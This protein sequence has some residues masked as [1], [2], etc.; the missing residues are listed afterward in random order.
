MKERASLQYSVYIEE[1][2]D[3]LRRLLEKSVSS[4][5]IVHK[6]LQELSRQ[7]K[8]NTDALLTMEVAT[9][10]TNMRHETM[11]VDFFLHDISQTI[12][13]YVRHQ[14]QQTMPP[15]TPEATLGAPDASPSPGANMPIPTMDNLKGMLEQ[16]QRAPNFEDSSSDT[17][18][19]YL[20]DLTSKLQEFKDSNDIP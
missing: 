14:L 18:K 2:G 6:Q 12:A 5:A 8:G 1:V 10:L 4:A 19:D 11:N 15:D 17:Q 7:T 9:Q 13:A 3:E 16:L 20:Q